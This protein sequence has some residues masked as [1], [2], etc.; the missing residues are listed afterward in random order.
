M[1]KGSK[2]GDGRLGIKENKIKMLKKLRV[3][4]L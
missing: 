4:V 3:R 1:I 2:T